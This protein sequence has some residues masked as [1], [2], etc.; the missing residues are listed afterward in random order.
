MTLVKWAACCGLNRS[1]AGGE[2]KVPKEKG[3]GWRVGV[4]F[5]TGQVENLRGK[6]GLSI[7]QRVCDLPGGRSSVGLNFHIGIDGD[8]GVTDGR[9]L[10]RRRVLGD[11]LEIGTGA[12]DLVGVT[13]AFRFGHGKRTGR[14]QV[15]E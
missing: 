15:I 11:D 5:E 2:R 12:S 10:G 1:Y 8:G 13:V 6:P 9:T 7:L 14:D 3:S 4:D